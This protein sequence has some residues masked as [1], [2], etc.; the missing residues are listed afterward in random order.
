MIISQLE[1]IEQGQLYLNTVS[2]K[3]YTQ[4][5]QPNFISSA[6]THMRHIIDHY[7]AIMSG[8]EN[9]LINYDLRMRGG[10]IE[11]S[12]ELAIAKLNEIANWIQGMS[13]DK[14]NQVITLAT[15]VSVTN[16]NIQ[17]LQTS[18]ARELVFVGSHATHHYAM[19]AQITFAQKN[20]LQATELPQDFGL[21]PATATFLRQ[22]NEQS[23]D[24]KS[25]NKLLSVIN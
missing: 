12:P 25:K 6:G 7:L 15:E 16:K 24:A 23:T 19:I 14:L 10:Q 1:I 8:I 21:A 17:K 18:V 9:K 13:E 2:K 11:L 5:V 20:A 4:I 22:C 3:N